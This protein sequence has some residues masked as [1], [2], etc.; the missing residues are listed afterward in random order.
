MNYFLEG[1]FDDLF[2][3]IL[4][5]GKE[6]SVVQILQFNTTIVIFDLLFFRRTGISPTAA[7]P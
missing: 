3:G 1:E 7:R 5:S 6:M 4:A 2:Y